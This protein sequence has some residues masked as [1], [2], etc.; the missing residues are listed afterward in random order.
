[1]IVSDVVSQV[2][3]HL[4]LDASTQT[5]DIFNGSSKST[6]ALTKGLLSSTEACLLDGNIENDTFITIIGKCN[7]DK[8][9]EVNYF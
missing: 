1:V 6:I 4:A 2:V 3:F 5:L 7:S 8:D 9:F